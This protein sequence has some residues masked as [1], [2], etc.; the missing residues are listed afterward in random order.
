MAVALSER[1]C[2]PWEDFRSRLIQTIG[3]WEH[4]HGADLAEKEFDPHDSTRC[5]H[6]QWSYYEQWL[7]AF[8]SLLLDRGMIDKEELDRRTQ[9][10]M[11]TRRDETF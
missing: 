10:F 6:A 9:E 5:G 11:T 3:H 2:Y 4:E 8:E 1:G 7:A